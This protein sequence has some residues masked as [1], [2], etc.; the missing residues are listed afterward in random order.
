MVTHKTNM[1]R[2]VNP[3][4]YDRSKRG[5]QDDQTHCSKRHRL[6][7]ANTYRGESGL[8]SC[9]DCKKANALAYQRAK[10][11]KASQAPDRTED[12]A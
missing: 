5:I 11:A 3:G 6:T 7:E 10:A 9:L 4:Q 1:E 12:G 2:A 8:R